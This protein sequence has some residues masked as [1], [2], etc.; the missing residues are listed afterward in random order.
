M[1]RNETSPQ[2]YARVGGILYLLLIVLGIFYQM[3]V[4]DSIMVPG[5]SI[6]TMENLEEREFFWRLGIVAEFLSALVGFGLVLVMYRLTKPV[7]KDLAM[8]AAFFNLAATTI[9]TVYVLQLVEA[10]FPLGASSYLQ[11]FTAEQLAAMISL[12]MKSHVFGFGIALLMFG[13]YFLITGYLIYKSNYLPKFIGVLYTISGVGYLVNSFMLI[14]APQ[15]SGIVF[16][17]IVLPVLVGE[18]S[19]AL[20]LLL[21]GVNESEWRTYVASN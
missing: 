7:N 5:D 4:R 21:K 16:M 6:A 9:Q 3:I 20:R 1:N 17:I 13:P 15:L 18:I 11:A 19:L 10:L 12:S 8:L 14:L 2:T